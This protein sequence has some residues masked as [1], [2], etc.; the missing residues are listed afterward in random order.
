MVSIIYQR[1]DQLCKENGISINKLENTLDFSPSTIQKWKAVTSPSVEKVSAI[2]NYFN[3]TVDYLIGRSDIR[4]TA[5][6]I[7]NDAEFITLQR[8]K[9]NM[10]PEKREQFMKYIRAGFDYV[11]KED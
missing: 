2:A 8:A 9:E 4:S 7:L 1:V 5:Q 10:S 6:D 3:V 11:F